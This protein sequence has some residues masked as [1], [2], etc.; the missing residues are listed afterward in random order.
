[1]NFLSFDKI[2]ISSNNKFS[3]HYIVFLFEN[4]N[5]EKYILL[6]ESFFNKNFYI[7]IG[8]LK[9]SNIFSYEKIKE[10]N[11]FKAK[12]KSILIP[13]KKYNK[14]I[15]IYL[16]NLN[17]NNLF[18]KNNEENYSLNGQENLYLRESNNSMIVKKNIFSE[19]KIDIV[20][21]NDL[22]NKNQNECENNNIL[23]EDSN[24]LYIY[25]L[26][27]Y[28]IE[29]FIINNSNDKLN[30]Y[31]NIINFNDLYNLHFNIINN[32]NIILIT[33]NDW[34]NTAYR[35]TKSLKEVNYR[36]SMIKLT[37]HIF[38][39]KYQGII[40]NLKKDI[41]SNYP[42]IYNIED[43]ENFFINLVNNFKNIW[44][45]AS[46][47]PYIQ[48]RSIIDYLS[49]KKYFVSH[50]G[51]TYR[52]NM[53]IVSKYFNSI[54][55]STLIQCP[56]LLKG[57][58]NSESLIYYPVDINFIKPD[59]SFKNNEKL[60]ISH[61]PS[62]ESVKGSD[63]I[64]P[65]LKKFK[66]KILLNSVVEIGKNKSRTD[67]EN[68]LLRYKECD[69]YVETIK[70]ILHNKDFGEWG[71]TCLEA[72][73]SGCIVLTNCTHLDLYIKNY[74]N[75]P[76][77]LICNNAL[78]LEKNIELLIKMSREEVLELKIK[79]RKWCEEYHN[80]KITGEKIR[81]LFL[82]F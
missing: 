36:M 26:D 33:N 76:P 31:K 18:Y 19:I 42:S 2:N 16:F 81:S 64:V 37:K 44:F 13:I 58:S 20:L 56:D 61:Y 63:I 32:C 14:K 29:Y 10:K 72:A 66:D 79:F 69:V 34:S 74:K 5:N 59:F 67:W 41:I 23:I 17:S 21:D 75:I 82:K 68:N 7:V 47:I 39:Y 52:N 65:I 77:I 78:E 3:F 15:F 40:L 71:N 57:K 53:P 6:N 1:M 46:Q 55:E 11:L 60:V 62:T 48:K 50:G 38:N 51:T 49:N 70:P 28:F 73:A 4:K 54:C 12:L 22:C 25:T 43:S 45:H 30:Y 35:F 9:E 80:F 24:N 8:D 27:K